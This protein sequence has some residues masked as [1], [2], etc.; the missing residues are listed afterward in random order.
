MFFQTP[1]F[2]DAPIHLS[3]YSVSPQISDTILSTEL[4]NQAETIICGL[5]HQLP[6]SIRTPCQELS[7]GGGTLSSLQK[8]AC[9]WS[10]SY[11]SGYWFW[12]SHFWNIIWTRLTPFGTIYCR[13]CS[14]SPQSI[15]VTDPRP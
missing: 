3:G 13:S 10:K 15:F 4:C 8:D 1:V 12:H 14:L 11:Y 5:G 6:R 7:G 2:I 9:R